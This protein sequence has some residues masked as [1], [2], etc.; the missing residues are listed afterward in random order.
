MSRLPAPRLRPVRP[1]CAC[2]DRWCG[3]HT[4]R[5]CRARPSPRNRVE[6][7]RV[8]W[9]PAHE[10]VLMCLPCSRFSVDSLAFAFA[11]Q[12]DVLP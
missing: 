9:D 5:T 3:T 2:R 8:E 7:R 12:P 4:G 6:V 10:P 1:A 11:E